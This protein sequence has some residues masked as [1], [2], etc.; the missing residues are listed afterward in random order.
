MLIHTI[1][2][3]QG[4]KIQTVEESGSKHQES[5]FLPKLMNE[6]KKL[7]MS[8]LNDSTLLEFGLTLGAMILV[9]FYEVTDMVPSSLCG[10]YLFK[11]M[12]LGKEGSPCRSTIWNFP[13]PF[14]PTTLEAVLLSIQAQAIC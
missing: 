13:E 6:N 10:N 5:D 12:C 8:S 9:T 4:K 7:F 3:L 14:W 2:L 11:I 1:F